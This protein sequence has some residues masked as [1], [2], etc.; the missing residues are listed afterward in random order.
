MYSACLL[1]FESVNSVSKIY[2]TKQKMEVNG[3]SESGK[4]HHHRHRHK[5]TSTQHK[6]HEKS[7]KQ[8]HEV[9]HANSDSQVTEC[10]MNKTP[11]ALE[12]MMIVNVL[13]HLLL[14]MNHYIPKK[15]SLQ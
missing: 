6:H 8:R 13:H 2:V 4:R 11:V 10:E 12:T 3:K 9:L 5:S 7:S 15:M 1:C 14:L